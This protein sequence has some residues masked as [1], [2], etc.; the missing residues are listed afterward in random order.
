MDRLPQPPQPL[1][2]Q[3]RLELLDAFE[4]GETPP[5]ALVIGAGPERLEEIFGDLLI[6]VRKQEDS[7]LFRALARATGQLNQAMLDG[8]PGRERDQLDLLERIL[9]PI[10][11]PELAAPLHLYVG[12][13]AHRLGQPQRAFGHFVWVADNYDDHPL[14]PLALAASARLL[15]QRPGG[16]MSA[17]ELCEQILKRYPASPESQLAKKRLLRS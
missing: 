3:E 17:Q 5:V 6:H 4:I 8:D 1:S 9:K 12:A 2:R 14:A 13:L 11:D 15:G 16:V 7:G 10:A